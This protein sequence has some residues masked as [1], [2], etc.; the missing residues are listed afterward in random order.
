M[1]N[2]LERNVSMEKQV[3]TS[4]LRKYVETS[5]KLTG[6]DLPVPENV[7]HIFAWIVVKNV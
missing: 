4:Q 2:V 1:K 3:N 7:K 5:G 6:V